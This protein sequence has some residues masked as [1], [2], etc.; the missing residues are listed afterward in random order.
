MNGIQSPSAVLAICLV[1]LLVVAVNAS[2]WFIYKRGGPLKTIESL[3]QTGQTVRHPFKRE[4]HDLDELARRVA[5]LEE[6]PEP[7]NMERP[8]DKP[9]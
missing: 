1:I 5:A 7:P 6:P 3:R 8:P 9:S 4:D 2:L